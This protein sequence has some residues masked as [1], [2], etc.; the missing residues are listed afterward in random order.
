MT[1]TELDTLKDIL[2]A[3]EWAV[4]IVEGLVGDK[5]FGSA[6][7]SVGLTY[8]PILKDSQKAIEET[9]KVLSLNN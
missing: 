3:A 9:K 7:N 4:G 1:K 2:I 5:D 8:Q 6:M